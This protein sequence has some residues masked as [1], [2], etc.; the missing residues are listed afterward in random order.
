VALCVGDPDSVTGLTT[1]SGEYL[2]QVGRPV[3]GR[4]GQPFAAKGTV[5]SVRY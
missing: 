3:G 4:D 5:S 1:Y 2:T